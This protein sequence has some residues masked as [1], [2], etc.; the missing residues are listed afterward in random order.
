M[1]SALDDIERVAP[2]VPGAELARHLARCPGEILQAME[3]ARRHLDYLPGTLGTTYGDGSYA[4][5]SYSNDGRAAGGRVALDVGA[6]RR[7]DFR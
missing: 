1:T 7:S 3:H 2:K 5:G 6:G 4:D